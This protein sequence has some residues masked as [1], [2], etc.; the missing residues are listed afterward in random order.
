M[1]CTDPS[2]SEIRNALARAIGR[3]VT[4]VVSA[5]DFGDPHPA[6]PADCPGVISVAATQPSGALADYS[7]RGAEITIAAPGGGGPAGEAPT[8][9]L[10][11]SMLPEMP[12]PLPHTFSSGGTDPFNGTAGVV[13][14]FAHYADPIAPYRDALALGGH[15]YRHLSGTSMA[16]P[17]VTGTVGL[18]K[19][20]NSLI[21][22]MQVKDILVRTA[23]TNTACPP[24][25]CGAGLL[26][27]HAATRYAPDLGV[28]TATALAPGFGPVPVDGQA[29]ANA[30]ITNSGSAMLIGGFGDAMQIV[31]GGGQIEFAY[32]SGCTSGPTCFLPF[33]VA[34]GSSSPVPLRCRPTSAG[35]INAILRIPSNRFDSAA[36]TVDATIDLPIRCDPRGRGTK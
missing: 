27:A 16:A 24:G 13:A 5:G 19:S 29:M 20:R 31:G 3:G 15:C 36:G 18:M 23:Q 7:N 8:P 26:N 21:T 22:A 17:H 35:T 6:F 14:P 1:R 30:L 10:F 25:L 32:S 11:G 9:T 28:P 12:C 2:S 4:V 33:H 34:Q